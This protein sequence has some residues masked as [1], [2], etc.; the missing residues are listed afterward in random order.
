MFYVLAYNLS[1]GKKALAYNDGIVGAETLEEAK[2]LIPNWNGYHKAGLTW[3]TTATL[4]WMSY[5]PHIVTFNDIEEIEPLIHSERKVLTERNHW[6]S[7]KYI[8]LVDNC[9]LNVIFDPKLIDEG[10]DT[11]KPF[12]E[13]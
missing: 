4:Y 7:A 11:A 13:K 3:S 10:F 5:H 2:K 8:L 9:Q 1:N 6:G 12:Y